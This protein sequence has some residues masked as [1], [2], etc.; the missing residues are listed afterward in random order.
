MGED[1]R[2]CGLCT[3]VCG[4]MWG[5]GLCGNAQGVRIERDRSGAG[6]CVKC[7]V[8]SGKCTTGG[9]LG[10]VRRVGGEI[11]GVHGFGCGGMS[12]CVQGMQRGGRA[13]RRKD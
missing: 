6:I 2:I 5:L 12:L 10:R 4:G 8:V 7:E 9:M 3:R 11:N 13:L 1:L